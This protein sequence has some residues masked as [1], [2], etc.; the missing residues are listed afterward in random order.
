MNSIVT[1]SIRGPETIV[2]YNCTSVN[3]KPFALKL[4]G[5]VEELFKETGNKLKV[6]G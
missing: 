1:K 3:R 2:P 6:H 4:F 5:E